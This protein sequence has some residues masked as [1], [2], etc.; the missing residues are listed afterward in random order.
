M[1]LPH[2]CHCRPPFCCLRPECSC[3]I[4]PTV[5]IVH[6]GYLHGI[7]A[8]ACVPDVAAVPAVVG[9][10]TIA[11]FP[12]VSSVHDA[13]ASILLLLYFHTVAGILAVARIPAFSG[14]F[15]VADVPAV[16]PPYFTY[17]RWFPFVLSNKTY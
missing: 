15:T 2:P 17:S 8:V 5:A 3:S 4:E 6:V 10:S 16:G 9:F 13:F 14:V 1:L 11:C 12:V 7:P